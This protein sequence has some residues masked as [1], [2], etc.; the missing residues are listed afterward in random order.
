MIQ[1]TIGHIQFNVRP[2]N[3]GFYKGLFTFAGWKLLYDEPEM[4]AAACDTGA[5]LWFSAGANEARNDYDGVGM[6]HFALGVANQQDVDAMVIYMQEHDIQPLFGTPCH[7][8]DFSAGPGQTYYQVMFESPDHILFE[9]V[10]I[11]IRS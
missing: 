5:S 3:L 9:V 4:L 2:E 1:S 6:N 10:Y 7:R 8:P 11:G